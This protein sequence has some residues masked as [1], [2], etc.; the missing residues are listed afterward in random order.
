MSNII[1][2]TQNLSKSYKLYDKH[3]DRLK[4]SLHPLRKKYHHNFY[5]LNNVSLEI[6]EGETVGIIGKNGSGK[7]TL[8]KIIAGVL[9]PTT[10]NILINGKVSALIELGTGFNPEL[11]GVEN[12]YLYNMIMGF[13]KKESDAKLDSIL[14]FADIGAFAY[15]PVKTY[16][17]GMFARLAFAV[18]INVDPDIFIIDEVLSVGD[19]AFQRKC[20]SQMEQFRKSGK[21]IIFV[22]HVPGAIVELC[23]RAILIDGGEKILEGIPKTVVNSYLKLINMSHDKSLLFRQRLKDIGSIS[24]EDSYDHHEA[25]SEDTKHRLN[26]DELKLLNALPS[27]SQTTEF[28]IDAINNQMISADLKGA[29]EVF[30]DGEKPLH[31][32]GWAIDRKHESPA[33]GV[34]VCVNDRF[35]KAQYGTPRPDIALHFQ[36]DSY[37]HSGFEVLIPFS[38]VKDGRQILSLRIMSAD[39]EYCYSPDYKILFSVHKTTDA[40]FFAPDLKSE[41]TVYYQSRGAQITN[42]T[43][44]TLDGRKVNHLVH[45]ERYIYSYDVDILEDLYNVRFG[46]L[47]KTTQGF[48][49]GG[50]NYPSTTEYIERI[51]ANTKIHIKWEF[52][53]ILGEGIYFTNAGLVYCDIGEIFFAHRILDAYI[54]R[55]LPKKNTTSWGPI[56]FGIKPMMQYY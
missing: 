2:A 48:E 4:E 29:L 5:A 52:N 12:I 19:V 43:I 14:A 21:T 22:S 9:T 37:I 3:I 38:E 17:S 30:C 20:F 33:S 46:M 36:N 23:N 41:S 49:L 7:S 54:F 34:I 40:A 50:A 32:K 47:I 39:Q 51:E 6:F 53:C 31:I 15:Q 8:L 55:V 25:L 1:V 10:G 26:D 35:Y 45:N 13:S 16:S 42:V 56:D 44:T 18:A 24:M 28:S 27:L 11:T